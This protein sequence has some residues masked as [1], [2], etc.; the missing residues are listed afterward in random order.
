MT[1]INSSVEWC[2]LHLWWYHF[3]K[4]SLRSYDKDQYHDDNKDNDAVNELWHLR[5][6]LQFFQLKN[7]IDINL[8][9]LRI[10]SDS[11]QHF[12]FLQCLFVNVKCSII[13]NLLSCHLLSIK[14]WKSLAFRARQE[15]WKLLWRLEIFYEMWTDGS[16]VNQSKECSRVINWATIDNT[17]TEAVVLLPW[18]LILVDRWQSWRWCS[19]CWWSGWWWTWWWWTRWWWWWWFV[20]VSDG[21]SHSRECTVNWKSDYHPSYDILMNILGIYT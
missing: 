3:L 11:G 14:P 15:C 4:D 10:E 16:Q 6:W 21:A 8:R 20:R 18:N 13:A 2:Y 1:D 5:H 7:L 17:G 19:G 12:Q 9:G